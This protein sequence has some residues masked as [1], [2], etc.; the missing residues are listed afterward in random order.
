MHPPS[1][2]LPTRRVRRPSLVRRARLAAQR[3]PAHSVPAEPAA[4]IVEGGFRARPLAWIRCVWTRLD[5]S[6]SFGLAAEMAF[7]M[8]LSLLPLAAV[9]G[10]V[11]A[12][13]ATG[14]R[15]AVAPLL[16]SLPQATRQMV[17][18]ELG[19]VAAWNGGK[20]GVG[21]GLMFIWLASSGVHSIFD[22]IELESDAAPRPWWKKRLLGVAT[23][24]ALSFG[25]ALLTVLGV[26]L[27]WLWR[28]AGG[29]TSLD[30][31]G[32]SP[33]GHVVRLAIGAAISFGLVSG[34]YWIAL[35]PGARKKRAPIAPGAL[36]AVVLQVAVGFGYG[37]YIQKV[38]D[39]G[40]YQ[41]GLAS[42]GVT[43]MALYLLSLVLLVGT[44]VNEMIG[45][46]RSRAS[47]ATDRRRSRCSR[48][49]ARDPESAPE[50]G[51]HAPSNPKTA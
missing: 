32:S 14:S 31:L 22:G 2:H 35:P 41:A 23:C 4:D 13:L 10:L 40:A 38:G 28:F 36:V 26:G 1:P 25:V 17:A 18:D 7:W 16:D 42:I 45:E 51:K 27:G 6:R 11:T 46:Q 47:T 44:K 5:K 50:V 30:A 33:A 8:F 12:K 49:E 3:S 24:V 43:L 9:A 37:F 39:G 48:P 29:S 34:L 15:S 19:R 21:A 20:V